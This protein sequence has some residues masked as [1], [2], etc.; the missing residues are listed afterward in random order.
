MSGT[1]VCASLPL[2]Q[3]LDFLLYAPTR[4]CLCRLISI[5]FAIHVGFFTF[6]IIKCYLGLHLVR[7]FSQN[8]PLLVDFVVIFILLFEHRCD[9]T[10]FSWP[11]PMC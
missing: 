4:L 2:A 7:C 1:R 10:M 11:D 9:K 6:N 5:S 3:C 8:I